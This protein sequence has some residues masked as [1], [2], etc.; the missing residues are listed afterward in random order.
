MSS[1]MHLRSIENR[2]AA[3]GAP[4]PPPKASTKLSLL[5]HGSSDSSESDD[6][7]ELERLIA[8][9]PTPPPPPLPSSRPKQPF[10]KLTAQ[11]ENKPRPVRA[12]RSRFSRV[13][14]VDDSESE[15]ENRQ[16]H[17]SF[18]RS[19]TGS[20]ITI[21]KRARPN[22]ASSQDSS[23][24]KQD[25]LIHKLFEDDLQPSSASK[26]PRIESSQSKKVRAA[27]K[28]KATP[29]I[30]ESKTFDFFLNKSSVE[31]PPKPPQASSRPKRRSAQRAIDRIELFDSLQNADISEDEPTSRKSLKEA[32]MKLFSSDAEDEAD[33]LMA[34][35]NKKATKKPSTSL[36]RSKTK[37]RRPDLNEDDFEK[38]IREAAKEYDAIKNYKLIVERT[39]HD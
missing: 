18:S 30:N 3:K 2:A 22:S 19:P 36:S 37:S 14:F 28:K 13:S 34:K 23:V 39:H 33:E 25:D 20:S 1:K 21:T 32:N 5:T 26:R 12:A 9:P 7:T 29:Q 8:K 31:S 10:L 11:D 24:S 15:K 4:P 35:R 27:T 38:Q 16:P 17:V 6:L